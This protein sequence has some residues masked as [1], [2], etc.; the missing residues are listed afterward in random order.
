MV[1]QNALSASV[2]SV[3]ADSR[4]SLLE[5]RPTPRFRLSRMLRNGTF[6]DEAPVSTSRENL[7]AS[8]P[9]LP[10]V[11]MARLR[12]ACHT[13][14]AH[15]SSTRRHLSPSLAVLRLSLWPRPCFPLPIS[16]DAIP[17]KRLR[18]SVARASSESSPLLPSK[19]PSLPSTLPRTPPTPIDPR[20]LSPL[21]AK[22]LLVPLLAHLLPR[23]SKTFLA[24]QPLVRPSSSRTL[25]SSSTTS[26]R[27]I[28][29]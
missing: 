29:S 11:K 5:P 24:L 20:F 22:A 19:S 2:E 16:A 1:V 25:S 14:D 13:L 23:I 6:L 8:S 27:R 7:R 9:F 15:H 10:R 18:P 21:S 26:E 3:Q 4:P 12:K 28:G 17:P